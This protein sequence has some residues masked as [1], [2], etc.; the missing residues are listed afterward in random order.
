VLD[1]LDVDIVL[2]IVPVFLEMQLVPSMITITLLWMLAS[3]DGTL[4]RAPHAI[5]SIRIVQ[6]VA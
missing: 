3:M 1:R 4:E 5:I 2:Q 6:V